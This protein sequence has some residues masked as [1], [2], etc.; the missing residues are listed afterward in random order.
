MRGIRGAEIAMIFQEPMTSLNPV[1]TVGDQI[2]E[3][4]RLHQGKDRAAAQRRGAADAASR[5]ASPKPRR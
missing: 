2:G 5:C 1:F 4:I 3:S